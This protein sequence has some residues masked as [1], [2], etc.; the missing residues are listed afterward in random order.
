MYTL[1]NLKLFFVLFGYEAWLILDY[2]R[3]LL[4]HFVIGM[5]TRSSIFWI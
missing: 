1:I 4:T 3:V 2:I 5:L